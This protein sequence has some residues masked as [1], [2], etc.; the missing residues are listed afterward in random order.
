MAEWSWL[1]W[2]IETP[3]SRAQVRADDL[4]QLQVGIELEDLVE[5]AICDEDLLFGVDAD[6]A[7]VLELA[8]EVGLAQNA[9]RHT[10]LHESTFGP[11]RDE[12]VR[13]PVETE[14]DHV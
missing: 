4:Q 10:E 12:D 13:V 7:R 5:L 2:K 11:L 8:A 3:I 14:S 9:A 1:P 6:A